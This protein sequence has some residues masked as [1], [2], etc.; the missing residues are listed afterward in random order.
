M[1]VLAFFAFLSGIVTI[2]SPCILPVLPI[3]LSGSI[4]GKSK[5]KGIV[6]GFIV[7]FSFITLALSALVQTLSIPPDL[8][9]NIAVIVI[10]A[11]GLTLAL[12]PLQRRFE[13]LASRLVP[14][15]PVAKGTGFRGGLAVGM[16][17]GL[18]WAP[19]VGP[20]MASVITLAVSRHVD[21]GAVIIIAS[22]AL[23]TSLPLFAVMTGGRKLL[24]RF[25]GL[26]SRTAG[27]QR[28]FGIIMMITALAISLGGDRRLQT[29]VL[30]AFPHYGTGLTTFEQLD[31]VQEALQQRR[32][33]SQE[34]EGFT[35]DD[36][37]RKGR[38][39]RYGEA[40]PLIAEG[41][42]FNTPEPLD[43]EG[44]RGKVVLVDFWTYSCINCVRTLPY[45]RQWYDRYAE[46]GLEVV[47]VHSPEFPFE[48][49]RSNLAKAI[50]DLGVSWPVVMDNSFAQW[51]A[52]GNRYWPAHFFID[53][54]GTIRYFHFG[55]GAYEESEE[56]I[57]TLLKEAGH[58]IEKTA[59]RYE[60]TGSGDLTPET[61][62]GYRRASG[63]LS[64][65]Q[66]DAEASY[67]F[68]G[69]PGSGEW[70]LEGEWTIRN[71]FIELRGKGGLE[72][73][74]LA[75]DV[76]LVIE[77]LSEEC[78][79]TVEVDGKPG[80][81]T[82]DVTGGMLRPRESRLYHLTELDEVGDHILSIRMKGELRLF[83]FTFG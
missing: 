63:F 58:E 43:M 47:G 32:D 68:A 41:P 67:G 7:S 57:R 6:L 54:E 64:P 44:L 69:A 27:I 19:C 79:L 72:L 56:V 24:H 70:S 20:I 83:A 34:A 17:L 30:Q 3:V 28:L 42:W 62:L 39:G 66:Q 25:S 40:P 26:T 38:T 65:V 1:T 76:F 10:F 59:A 55:E 5:P 52:Y 14:S 77:P 81:D 4:G 49:N 12:P 13:G 71:D 75:K 46:S 2:L 60:E 29:L 31:I 33:S 45:L 61:Y 22:Y 80:G 8:L 73:G 78:S 23:G 37:P 35:W 11:F 74:F 51:R 21:G 36:P 16:S 82:P 18:L 53:A 15:R 9:R 48:R 50:E